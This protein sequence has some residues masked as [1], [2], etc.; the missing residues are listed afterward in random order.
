MYQL[1]KD[2]G[3]SSYS[4]NYGNRNMLLEIY[5]IAKISFRDRYKKVYQGENE[6]NKL[7]ILQY[8]R[9]T[10]NLHTKDAQLI[11]ASSKHTS[12]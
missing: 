6:I 3:I 2:I 9:C 1:K 11:V 8:Y 4:C 12:P 7:G 5:E 10:H